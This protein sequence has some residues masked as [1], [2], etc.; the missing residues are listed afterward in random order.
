[1]TLL[2]ELGDTMGLVMLANGDDPAHVTR[3]SRSTQA[4]TKIQKA[5]NSGQIR[6]F[7]GN[8]YAPLLAKGDVW[9]ASPGRATSSSSRPTT[10]A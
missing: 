7:T 8:D 10:R 2:T 6:Q 3:R 9:A 4:P 5:V 1:M